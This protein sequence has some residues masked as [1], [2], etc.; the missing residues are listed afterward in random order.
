MRALCLISITM[1]LVALLSAGCSNFTEEC[2]SA[3]LLAVELNR[4]FPDLRLKALQGDIQG[5]ETQKTK[6]EQILS[7]MAAHKITDDSRKAK[8]IAADLQ[9]YYSNVKKA[10]VGF[11]KLVV[12]A[13]AYSKNPIGERPMLSNMEG[14][15]DNI[16]DIVDV[17]LKVRASLFETLK[18][19]N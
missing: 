13:D 8:R 14:L 15:P 6:V 16:D 10:I 5:Y 2:H 1:T 9:D 12:A 18:C 3:Q 7:K 11:D 17:Q 4:E 19:T